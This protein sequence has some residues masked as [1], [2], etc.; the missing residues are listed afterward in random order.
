MTDKINSILTPNILCKITQNEKVTNC[1]DAM[2][3]GTEMAKSSECL[4]VPPADYRVNHDKIALLYGVVSDF[5]KIFEH[6]LV[7]CP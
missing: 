3:A 1:V 4:P 5:V 7:R 2:E 6:S